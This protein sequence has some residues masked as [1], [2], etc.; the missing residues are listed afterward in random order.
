MQLLAAMINSNRILSTLL[1]SLC[2]GL[3]AGCKDDDK[4][5]PGPGTGDSG[6]GGGGGAWLVGQDGAMVNVAL[7]GEIGDYDLG[8]EEDL[9][10][11]DCRGAD[12]A[13]VVG[14]LGTLLRTWDAG[15]SWAAL[16]LGTTRTLRSV[17]VSEGT[18]LYV[19]GDRGFALRSDDDGDT[20]SELVAGSADITGVSTNHDGALALMVDAAGAVWRWDGSLT[21]VHQAGAPLSAVSL[22]AS[23]RQAFAVGNGGLLLRSVDSGITWTAVDAG[24]G[25]ALFDVWTAADGSAAF[26]VGEG[27][28]LVRTD[29]AGST[30]QVVAPGGHSLRGIHL[31]I[32]GTGMVVGD[33]GTALVRVTTG[34]VWTPVDLGTTR[35]LHAVDDIHTLPHW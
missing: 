22:S 30:V 26:A 3:G 23:G 12:S 27:G 1:L 20:W 34:G 29:D 21:R 14:E 32:D 4:P 13:F 31:A 19:G 2:V 16:D 7:D 9:L 35:D 28:V 8:S 33:G 25:A 5:K 6:D 17:A 10:D 18:V 15:K 24:T 11:I